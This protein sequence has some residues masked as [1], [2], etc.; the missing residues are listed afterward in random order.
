[1]KLWELDR[2]YSTDT[3]KECNVVREKKKPD[4]SS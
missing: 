4:L 1:M 2:S 3:D